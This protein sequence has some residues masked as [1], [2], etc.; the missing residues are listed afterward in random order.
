MWP[1]KSCLQPNIV[2]REDW[3]ASV[4]DVFLRFNKISL[5]NMDA[6]SVIPMHLLRKGKEGK[7]CIQ[8]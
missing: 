3:M 5:K 2:T 6:L 8:G 1:G 7:E 4:D